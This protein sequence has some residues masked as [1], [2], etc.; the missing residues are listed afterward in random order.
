[1]DQDRFPAP[2]LPPFLHI[3][4][5]SYDSRQYRAYTVM[6]PDICFK[7]KVNRVDEI[8]DYCPHGKICITCL[9][10]YGRCPICPNQTADV[11][12]DYGPFKYRNFGPFDQNNF[13]DRNN[14]PF[15]PTSEVGGLFQ[16]HYADQK[17]DGTSTCKYA[18][19]SGFKPAKISSRR[20]EVDDATNDSL[21][22]ASESTAGTDC[23][24]VQTA[25]S[26]E[27]CLEADMGTKIEYN[28][29]NLNYSYQ[30]LFN[31]NE[32]DHYY[33]KLMKEIDFIPED[34]V[35]LTLGER[36]VKIPRRLAAY[37]DEGLVYKFNNYKAR[38]KKWTPV[39]LEIKRRVEDTLD[40]KFNFALVN[41]YRSGSDS[42]AQHRDDEPDLVPRSP[43]CGISFG[44]CRK[45]R[46]TKVGYD[47]KSVELEHG[48]MIVM[49]HPTNSTWKHG[50]PKCRDADPRIS[51]TFR[52]LVVKK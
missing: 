26:S 45:M 29:N 48:S 10:T 20:P 16:N 27:N 49:K 11:H 42:I 13:L 40:Y 39:L 2:E 43:I 5:P 35:I 6:P 18:E 12:P 44:G 38:A 8:H 37:G 4:R 50:I 32:A 47:S 21:T 17:N 28:L 14:G 3:P 52:N 1:M 19:S 23:Q 46:F 30:I 25:F 15:Q 22:N 7:C 41:Y 24:S 36:K 33:F 34:Q 31:V 9:A 51:I